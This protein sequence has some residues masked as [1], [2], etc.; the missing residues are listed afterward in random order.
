MVIDGF[1]PFRN[2]NIGN[3]TWL[4][5]LFPY[6][7]PLWMCMKE[8]YIFI[9]LLIPGPK[10]PGNDIDVYLRPLIDELKML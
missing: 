3:S 1:N 8:P 2:M 9:T 4:V 7:F 6:N 5:P 10:G